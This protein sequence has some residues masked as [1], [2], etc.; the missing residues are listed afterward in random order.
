MRPV[1]GPLHW[2]RSDCPSQ[3]LGLERRDNQGGVAL[4]L[5][6]GGGEGEDDQ[7]YTTFCPLVLWQGGGRRL[8]IDDV[9]A[10]HNLGI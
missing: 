8:G 9:L 10:W 4:C 5:L 2:S 1:L 6:A 7:D 3:L